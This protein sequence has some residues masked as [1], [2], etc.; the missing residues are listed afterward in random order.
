MTEHSI[1]ALWEL[2]MDL[3]RAGADV[4][5]QRLTDDALMVF[6]G[7]VLTKPQTVDSI[8]A[9]PRWTSVSFSDQRLVRL[10]EDA[11]AL[12][13]HASG[14]REGDETPYSARVSSVYVRREGEW[15]LALHQQSPS[16]SRV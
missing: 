16:P 15:R 8:V 6:P 4:Y 9:A 5:R 10:A 11:V 3:W 14:S 7:M 2:E 12:I 13:Y 1:P